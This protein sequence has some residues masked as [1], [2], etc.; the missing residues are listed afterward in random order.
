MLSTTSLTLGQITFI[1]RAIIQLL[2]HGGLFLIGIIV[3]ASVPRVASLKTHDVVNRAVGKSTF[4]K[5]SLLWTL[6]SFRGKAGDPS[7]PTN[8]FVALSDLGF[9]GLR[10]CELP[11]P[12]M[13]DRPSSINS[14]EQ[15]Q[16]A[17]ENATVAGAALEGIN[18]YRCN[19][20][21]LTNL[22]DTTQS[23][24]SSWENSTY[25]NATFFSALNSTDSDI[26][27]DRTLFDLNTYHIGPSSQ[28]VETATIRNGIAV[29]PDEMGVVAIFRLKLDNV[30]ALEIEMGCLFT[31]VFS[32]ED[33][34]SITSK[35]PRQDGWLF[36]NDGN[37]TGAA[38][39]STANVAYTSPSPLDFEAFDPVMENCTSKLRERLNLTEWMMC[40][41]ATQI[42]MVS[43]TILTDSNG[44]ISFS[45]SGIPSD[46]YHTRAEYFDAVVDGNDTSFVP[47]DG[48]D[49]LAIGSNIRATGIGS[50]GGGAML[51]AGSVM[52][53][54]GGNIQNSPLSFL[55]E[56]KNPID[57]RNGSLVAKWGGQVGASH[58]LESLAY[59]GWA[60]IS[61]PEMMINSTGGT[62]GTCYD[63]PYFAGF[64]PL[65]IAAVFVVLWTFC[66]LVT[67]HLTGSKDVEYLYG[68]LTPFWGVVSPHTN[69]EDTLLSWQ[70]KPET[71][72]EVV[73]Q[74]QPLLSGDGTAARYVRS[75]SSFF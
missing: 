22:A 73:Q 61:S 30:M 43:A 36:N 19:S 45:Y 67:F 33:L 57:F 46:L 53:D 5:S 42:N 21:Q 7:R 60:A 8:G 31:G 35:T 74:G 39:D 52:I 48:Y 37:E 15:A 9:L 20:A 40:A 11:G 12:T 27:D 58:I 64:I 50:G 54:Q 68:G 69:A 51:M 71:H 16:N 6:A 28:C 75:G 25:A 44:A 55:A 4:T 10:A 2:G 38:L 65:L 49:R 17:I 24:C 56:G 23:L 18:V 29:F 70:N 59:N 47:F 34:D 63:T 72:L 62:I 66:L 13:F 3:L 41:T 1:I 32:I 14:T 26:M